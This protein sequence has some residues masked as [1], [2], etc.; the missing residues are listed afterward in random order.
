M[1]WIE[2]KPPKT[3]KAPLVHKVVVVNYNLKKFTNKPKKGQFI[4]IME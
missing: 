3:K 1:S 2:R 4:D